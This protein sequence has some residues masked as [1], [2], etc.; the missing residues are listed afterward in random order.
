MFVKHLENIHNLDN[1][2]SFVK[3]GNFEIL[4]VNVHG[5]TL[6]FKDSITRNWALSHLWAQLKTGEKFLD[7]DKDVEI[8]Q[9]SEK[10]KI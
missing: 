6:V 3:V 10:Y 8:F 1:Y 4:L 9:A 5:T 2:Q 7:L